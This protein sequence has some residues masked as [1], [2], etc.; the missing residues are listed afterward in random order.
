MRLSLALLTLAATTALAQAHIAA[1]SEPTGTVTGHVFC[2][3]TNEPAR[4]AHVTLE[5]VPTKPAAKSSAST[6][7]GIALMPDFGFGTVE[8]SIDGSFTIR[9]VKPGSYYVVVDKEG[10]M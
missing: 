2:A 1:P 3:D 8:T 9:N 4:F 6:K 10:Y 5:T 7:G